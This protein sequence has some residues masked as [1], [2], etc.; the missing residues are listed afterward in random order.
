[1]VARALCR[2]SSFGP[3]SVSPRK[4]LWWG[5]ERL[6]FSICLARRWTF[7]VRRSAFDVHCSPFSV[8]R[9]GKEE[10][11]RRGRHKGS[12]TRSRGRSG[13]PY[14][15]ATGL[16]R[17]RNFRNCTRSRAISLVGPMGLIGLR[18]RI[19][20]R[21]RVRLAVSPTPTCPL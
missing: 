18:R 11:W 4:R 21:A 5:A 19:R 1:M 10:A 14:P 20:A 8:W 9:P 13:V 17:V 7:G 6:V 12:P 3:P 2:S 16:I 15:L